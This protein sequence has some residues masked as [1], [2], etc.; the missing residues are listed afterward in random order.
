LLFDR[1]IHVSGDSASND[2][3]LAQR[4]AA[5]KRPGTGYSNALASLKT[6][7]HKPPESAAISNAATPQGSGA[8]AGRFA[9]CRAYRVVPGA[10]TTFA[11]AA[12][13]A[14]AIA[15]IGTITTERTS[16]YARLSGKAGGASLVLI[17]CRSRPLVN[18]NSRRGKINLAE[19][20]A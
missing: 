6:T 15:S 10:I 2:H 16:G 3:A 5:Y 7:N 13:V 9:S 12:T 4:V 11:E 14:E 1:V 20:L 18:Y 17:V 19:L 8:S